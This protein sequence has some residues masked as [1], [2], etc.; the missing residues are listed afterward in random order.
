[1]TNPRLIP[2]S[3]YWVFGMHPEGTW[4]AVVQTNV[5][6]AIV[7]CGFSRDRT[8]ELIAYWKAKTRRGY[9]IDSDGSLAVGAV[10]VDPEGRAVSRWGR[11]P[12]PGGTSRWA[13]LL[14]LKMPEPVNCLACGSERWQGCW[15][16]LDLHGCKE[17]LTRD[18]VTD[19]RPAWPSE[20]RMPETTKRVVKIHERRSRSGRPAGQRRRRPI[21]VL[22]LPE[23]ARLV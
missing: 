17:C 3:P 23:Q 6:L 10:A 9:P 7:P 4:T 21:E 12:E 11:A 13:P 20:P 19:P 16:A 22:A 5:G 18:E 8:I 15:V 14:R 2:P 1:M